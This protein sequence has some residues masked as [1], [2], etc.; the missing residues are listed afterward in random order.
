MSTYCPAYRAARLPVTAGF[1]GSVRVAARGTGTRS[2]SAMRFSDEGANGL[3]QLWYLAELEHLAS[4]FASRCRRVRDNRARSAAV[5]N[6]MALFLSENRGLSTS[7]KER[8]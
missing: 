6:T 5:Q 4:Y 1:D 7:D 2:S 8:T 3:E